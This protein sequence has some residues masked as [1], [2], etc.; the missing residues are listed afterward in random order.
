MICLQRL[1]GQVKE[2][3]AALGKVRVARNK[4]QQLPLGMLLD[5]A[6]RPTTDP[7]AM[8]R[9]PCGALITFGE[10]K[11]YVLAPSARFLAA[12]S[13]AAAPCGRRTRLLARPLMAC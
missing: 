9:Q 7:N 12:R 11:G 6:G 5:G 3:A 8:Y 2:V 4:G 1:A 10:H 13:L